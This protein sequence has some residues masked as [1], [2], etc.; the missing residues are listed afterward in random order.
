VTFLID[1]DLSS[2]NNEHKPTLVFIHGGGG[3]KSQWNFQRDFF[4]ARGYGVLTLS[5]SGHGKTSRSSNSSI[6]DYV[7]ELALFISQI[8][9]SNYT[10]IGHSMGGGIVLSY[11]LSSSDNP[12]IAIILIGT[13]A[14]LNVA[15]IFFDLLSTDFNQVLRLMGKFNYANKT[16][17]KIKLTNQEILSNN[18][19]D[20]LIK[21]LK[22]CQQFD[23]RDRLEEI[24][25]PSLIICGNEDRMTPVKFSNFLHGK[26][27]NSHYVIVPN[28]GHFVFQEAP[29]DVNDAILQFL[30]RGMS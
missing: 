13:G 5:L 4:R 3:D 12:P 28:A 25:I 27:K 14:K 29:A 6:L 16:N 19:P 21:D 20:I 9:L 26:L 23:V 30:S 18:G 7:R 15:P 22:A 1:Y 11:V 24:E 10:L 2:P 17:V 8:R